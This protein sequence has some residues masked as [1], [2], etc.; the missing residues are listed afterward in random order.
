MALAWAGK[1]CSHTRHQALSSIAQSIR[2]AGVRRNGN[3]S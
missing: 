1:R 2:V 3:G